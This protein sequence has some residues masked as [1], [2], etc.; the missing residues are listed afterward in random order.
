MKISYKDRQYLKRMLKWR[1]D[2]LYR[3][4]SE[5]QA[6]VSAGKIT[7]EQNKKYWIDTQDKRRTERGTIERITAILFPSTQPT[8]KPE[9][10]GEE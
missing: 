3:L 10:K 6:E 7:P 8:A 5:T 9:E 2:H 4:I 1:G